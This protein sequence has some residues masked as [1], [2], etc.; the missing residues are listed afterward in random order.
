MCLSG[1]A[2][3]ELGREVA[4]VCASQRPGMEFKQLW[5]SIIVKDQWVRTGLI[6]GAGCNKEIRG[7]GY[8]L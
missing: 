2:C 5:L 4:F 1:V 6:R 8:K 7:G 3:V